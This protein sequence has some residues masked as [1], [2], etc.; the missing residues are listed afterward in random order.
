MTSCAICSPCSGC[1]LQPQ[2]E[3]VV[4]HAGDEGRGLARGQALLGLAGELRVLHLH[5]EHVG[6]A[7]PDVFWRQLE[8]ARQQAA[9]LAEL[10]HRLGQAGAQAVDVGTALRRSG[11]G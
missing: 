6:A 8:A 1:W 11:S 9:E 2:A 10:A 3:G 7:L 5:A 4:H